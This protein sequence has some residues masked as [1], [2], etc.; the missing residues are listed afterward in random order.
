MTASNYI[1]QATEL[2]VIGPM[3]EENF[4]EFSE[5]LRDH[6]ERVFGDKV[7]AVVWMMHPRAAFGGLSALEYAQSDFTYQ[8]V[9]DVLERI[10]HG[11][12]C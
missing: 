9:K 4:M 8:Q 1:V 3:R 5:L 12:A 11:F 7:Q 6:A 2:M 10:E